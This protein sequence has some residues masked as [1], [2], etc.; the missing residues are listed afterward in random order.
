MSA[1]KQEAQTPVVAVQDGQA[2]T[3]SLDVARYFRKRHKNVLQAIQKL[4]PQLPDHHLS[5]LNFQPLATN[6]QDHIN[7][8]STAVTECYLLT[9]DGFVMLAMGFTGKQALQFKVAYIDAFNAMEAEL[10]KDQLWVGGLSQALERICPTPP[11]ET[12]SVKSQRA[13]KVLQA[14]AAYWSM[15]EDMPLLAAET[16]VC[17]VGRIQRLEDFSFEQD[18]GEYAAMEDFLER[19]VA[20]SSKKN[21]QPATEQQI[22]TIK[23]LVD[24]CAQFRYSRD[25]NIYELLLADYGITVETIL[26]ASSGQAKQIAATVY[27]VLRQQNMQTLAINEIKRRAKKADE[28]KKLPKAEDSQPG[29]RP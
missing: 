27:T 29:E 20:R 15:I 25:R 8:G 13:V 23:S 21:N 12:P 1:A 10:K 17:T 4:I 22:N 2:V 9:R 7:S 18:Q 11:V 28:R 6:R 14:L 19:V 16:A 26:T 3:T 24:A 5:G